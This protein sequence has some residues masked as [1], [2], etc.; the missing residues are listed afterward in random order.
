MSDLRDNGDTHLLFRLAGEHYAAPVTAVEEVLEWQTVTPVPRCPAYLLG[1]INVRGTLIP[2]LDL[3]RRFDIDNEAVDGGAE[4]RILVIRMGYG[5]AR[6]Q[7]GLVVDGVEGVVD[8][9]RETLEPPPALGG[10][11]GAEAVRGVVRHGERILLVVDPDAVLPK[12]TL[13]A[14]YDALVGAAST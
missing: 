6:I 9:D 14:D 8:I 1:V 13:D 10:S 12:E 7:M 5:E 11:R 2:V 3:R 4:R